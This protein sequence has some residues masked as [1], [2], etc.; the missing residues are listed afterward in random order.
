MSRWKLTVTCLLACVLGI[1]TA[2]VSEWNNAKPPADEL[3]AAKVR[4]DQKKEPDLDVVQATYDFELKSGNPLH[5]KNLKILKALCLKGQETIY[6]CFVSFYSST[7]PG[8]RIYNGLTEI[9]YTDAGWILKSGLCKRRDG[10]YK[11]QANSR[12]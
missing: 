6:A 2:L 3:V 7:D 12:T 1:G 4:A 9:A 5:D 11:T 10:P 8:K